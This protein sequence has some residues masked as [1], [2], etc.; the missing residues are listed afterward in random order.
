M[1]E[2]NEAANNHTKRQIELKELEVEP[3]KD[4][5]KELHVSTEYILKT[6]SATEPDRVGDLC[7]DFN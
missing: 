1:G 7:K 2:A 3:E 4:R 5:V 6:A